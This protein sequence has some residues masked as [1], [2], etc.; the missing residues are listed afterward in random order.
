MQPLSIYYP[1]LFLFVYSL[2]T[3]QED[4]QLT[5]QQ[6][7]WE[8]LRNRLNLDPEADYHPERNYPFTPD[9]LEGVT[10]FYRRYTL[11]DTDSLL[12]CC[13]TKDKENPQSY[14]Y[15]YDFQK[16][17]EAKGTIGKTWL[18]LGYVNSATD[19]DKETTAKQAYQSFRKNLAEPQ[20]RPG[21]HFLGSSVF[22][23]W[24]SSENWT[25]TPENENVIICICPHK[26][27]VERIETFEY[28]LML[29]FYYRHKIIWNY[30]SSNHIKKM[31]I[32]E[33]IFPQDN[34]I[35][36]VIIKLPEISGIEQ[37]FDY[38]NHELRA[39][40]QILAKYTMALETL[41]VQLQ[42]LRQ[43]LQNYQN[44]LAIIKNKAAEENGLTKLNFL[45]E[46]GEFTAADYLWQMEQD[47]RILVPQLQ[48]R[49]KYI[50]SIRTFI[51]LFQAEQDRQ[52]A[53]QNTKFQD[54]VIFLVTTIGTSTLIAA[55][56]APFIIKEPS[57]NNILLTCI[58]LLILYL[59]IGLISG[60]FVSQW[61]RSEDKGR[62]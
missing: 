33:G 51:E 54:T 62:K 56:S 20:L 8:S 58:T 6:Q 15:F 43:N 4:I 2:R 31:L 11:G 27:I 40:L 28:E 23:I 46:F 37:N 14:D 1:H 45:E 21:N 47:Y 50:N 32:L 42:S 19:L 57:T 61:W 9:D 30:Q 17:L 10:G 22:E 35:D 44:R 39:N 16:K 26:K 7:S 52:I 41:K 25:N 24:E 5:P 48:V 38:F 59:A 53:S 55:T 18:I 12:V 29:L 3:I 60:Y 36:E 34:H 13:A 49:E